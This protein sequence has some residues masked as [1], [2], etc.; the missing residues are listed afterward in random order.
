M[1]RRA[2]E[3][4]GAL[5]VR[6]GERAWTIDGRGDAWSLTDEDAPATIEPA[7]DDL[8]LVTTGRA[9]IDEVLARTTIEGDEAT[10]RT[11][12]NGWQ[13]LAQ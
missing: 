11:I 9:S 12:L 4:S 1:R 7:P 8:V 10:A 6:A 2:I 3:P 13:V 5:R